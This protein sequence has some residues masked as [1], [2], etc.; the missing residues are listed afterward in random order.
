MN[1]KQIA[2]LISGYTF[3]ESIENVSNG[4]IFV[5]QGKNVGSNADILNSDGLVNISSKFLRNPS[6]LQYND[7]LIVA[8]GSG[9]GSFRSAIFTSDTKNV[10]ASSS[11]HIIR[12]T[13][14]TVLPKFL[15]LFL[16]SPEGQKAV[17]QIVTGGSYIQ[18]I[19]LKNLATLEIP[20]PSIH[21][22]KIIVALH[23]NILKQKIIQKR[24][25]DIQ[26]TILNATFI[27]LIK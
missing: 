21:T 10:M 20:I 4:D 8:R 1:L 18:S 5:I 15:C 14:V 27:K 19:L 22:Q 11:V 16:N 13:D 26:Q 25:S 9:P 17:S 6:F 12:I 23:E 24:K 3:R 2:I 7:I